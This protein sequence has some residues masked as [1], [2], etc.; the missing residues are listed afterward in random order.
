MGQPV[1][2]LILPADLQDCCRDIVPTADEDLVESAA[3]AAS[4]VAW[5]LAGRRHGIREIV[6]ER[7]ARP[8]SRWSA[9]Q[10]GE[11]PMGDVCVARRCR[12][13]GVRT[14]Y[15]S[16]RPVTEI[17]EVRLSGQVVDP[18]TYMLTEDD[19]LVGPDW[20]RC[21]LLEVDDD[22][23]GVLV[24]DYR[25]GAELD[26]MGRAAIAKLA[27]EMLKGCLNLECALPSGITSMSRQGI[28]IEILDP[29]DFL[30]DGRVGLY[31]FDLWLRTVNPHRVSSR[32]R[33]RTPD[34]AR[35]VRRRL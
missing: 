33:V 3:Q 11:Q 35:P 32:P 31:E 21:Q 6:A 14:L 29:F 16:Q 25:A 19:Q 5:A 15:L 8:R 7:P 9:R 26:P 2:D 10:H 4:V 17:M 28:D 20:P 22:A 23:E 1:T 27:C 24:V 30:Q 12:C 34:V 13:P 18:A